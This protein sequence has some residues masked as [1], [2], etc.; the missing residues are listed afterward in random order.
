MGQA[1][2]A[3]LLGREHDL[4]QAFR[5]AAP[6]HR[7]RQLAHGEV[8]PPAGLA[9]QRRPPE[10]GRHQVAG[11]TAPN[12]GRLEAE[13]EGG[14]DADGLQDRVAVADEASKAV[15][16]GRDPRFGGG[17]PC[18]PL[19]GLLQRHPPQRQVLVVA[20]HLFN[21]AF[22]ITWVGVRVRRQESDDRPA[23]FP[24]LLQSQSLGWPASAQHL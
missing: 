24:R 14:G 23:C 6:A 4:G 17:Q 3:R 18:L 11:H 20:L 16:D 19:L 7:A 5:L 2:A 15:R 8:G 10:R 1:Q 12:L 22:R 13:E 9:H 21:N